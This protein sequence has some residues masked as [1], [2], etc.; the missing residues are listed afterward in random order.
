MYFHI[1]D[2]CFEGIYVSIIIINRS[3]ILFIHL[4]IFNIFKIKEVAAPY[5]STPELRRFWQHDIR[6]VRDKNTSTRDN[7]S[8]NSSFYD[9]MSKTQQRA[10]GRKLNEA[11][12]EA[13]NDET[14]REVKRL[15]YG[16]H[17]PDDV[18]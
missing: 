5:T 4:F 9:D 17:G 11:V 14:F 1:S 2:N 16:Q 3:I 8:V 7:S 10:L 12:R 18:N 15:S 13:I 6:M